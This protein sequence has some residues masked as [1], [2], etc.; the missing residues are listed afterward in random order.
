MGQQR[1]RKTE[2]YAR[3]N[4]V[5]SDGRLRALAGII[6]RREIIQSSQLG[7]ATGTNRKLPG[8]PAGTRVG[9][10]RKH[11]RT[12]GQGEYCTAFNN[13]PELNMLDFSDNTIRFTEVSM[14][15]KPEVRDPDLS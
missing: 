11:M 3:T 8:R 6:T 4:Q 14:F 13:E 2:A 15:V 9:F 10:P 5:G 1:G 12:D 7:F